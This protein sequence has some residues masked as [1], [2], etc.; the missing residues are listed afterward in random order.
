MAHD[1][2]APLSPDD[3]ARALRAAL[4]AVEEL[5]SDV[6]ALAARVVALGEQVAATS[7]DPA[8]AEAAVDRRAAELTPAIAIA[9]AT[10]PGRL[11]L[12]DDVDKY[13]VSNADGP[14][15]LELLPICQGRCCSLNFALSPQDLDE[16][17]VRWDLGQPYLIRHGADGRCVHQ[18]D[19]ACGCY[20]HR[21]APCRAYDCRTDRRIW[22]DFDQRILTPAIVGT[23]PTPGERRDLERTRARALMLESLTLRPRR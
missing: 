18:R 22:L 12:G 13:Q 3:V 16:G 1:D 9:D 15:C 5:R 10:A 4:L 2:D 11:H 20:H 7:P 19:G 14:P 17:V 6:H 23:E 8:A 21:P